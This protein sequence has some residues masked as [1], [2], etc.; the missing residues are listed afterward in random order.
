MIDMAARVAA[1]R[2]RIE[3]ASARA[4]RDPAGVRLIAAAKTKSADLIERAIAAGVTDIGENYVQEAATHKATVRGSANWHMIGNL[5][6]NKAGK[7]VRLFDMIQTV[8]TAELAQSISRQGARRG[9]P[10]SVLVEVNL[11]GE[12]TKSGVSPELL[13]V[14]VDQ[15]RQLDGVVLQG[16]MTVPPSGPPESARPCFR[17]LRFLAERLALADLSM[18]MTDDFEVAI[19]E[20]ATMIR[21]GRAIFGERAVR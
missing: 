6:R 17:S 16:L 5:Q 10:V 15:L 13:P 11:V 9:R 19:E 1:V 21:V 12:V 2:E 8:D 3:K 7:A 4:G 14:L 18:G 20:G